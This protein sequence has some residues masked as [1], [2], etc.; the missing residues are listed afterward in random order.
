[1]DTMKLYRMKHLSVIAAV[2]LLCGAS[3]QAQ[4]TSDAALSWRVTSRLGY[5]PTPER[6]QATA[7]PARAA[8]WSVAQIDEAKAAS[9]KPATV[10]EALKHLKTPAP[11]I[12]EALRGEVSGRQAA[13]PA[14]AGTGTGIQ[15][16]GRP[17]AEGMPAAVPPGM[18]GGVP[19]ATAAGPGAGMGMGDDPQAFSRSMASGIAAWRMISCSNPDI[20]QPMLSRMTE[21]WFN[22]FNVFIAKGPVR[23]FVASY[24]LDAVRPN[25]FGKFEDL[26]LATAKHPA[27][28]FYLDQTLSVADGTP[29][30]ANIDPQAIGRGLN[31]N[32]ARELLELH[33][34]GVNGGYTQ[35]DVRELARILTG[36][37]AGVRE[38]TAFRFAPRLHDTGD[39]VLL[40][41][42]FSNNGV[43]EGEDAIRM[44]ARHPATAQRIAL[45]MAQWFVADNPSDALVQ[46]LAAEFTRTE[47]DI[48]AVMKVLVASPEFLT[49]SDDTRLVKT[50]VDTAC[51][52]TLA[53]NVS[54]AQ[55][56]REELQRTAQFLNQAG[57]GWHGWQTPDGY[58]T[59]AATWLAPEALTRRA[60]FVIQAT[61]SVAPQQVAWLGTY[62]TPRTRERIAQE[63]A[64]QQVGLMLASPE[65]MTK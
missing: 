20:E 27:M 32:Y 34:L 28:L 46:R 8:A 33:T 44:L 62:A 11:Q 60:D 6:A 24:V 41:K 14:L 57:Q 1:M 61:S 30:P 9:A 17:S 10:P 16:P 47:G 40:G 12:Y 52:T 51:S 18:A 39:K 21:F 31:E 63:P 23:P 3:A 29:I 15:R 42:T 56:G 58:K 36:W 45:R 4:T 25:A 55:A 22:H 37:G 13:G 65:F 2:A 26:L 5:G 7:T 49:V 38:G 53:R 50:P 35:K 19:G 64:N 43:K 54:G 48:A 59:N